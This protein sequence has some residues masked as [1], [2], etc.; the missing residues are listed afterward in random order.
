MR[1]YRKDQDWDSGRNQ[2]NLIISPRLSHFPVR[3]I[4]IHDN[5]LVKIY[6]DDGRKASRLTVFLD[7]AQP[8]WKG[9]MIHF[10]PFYAEEG[11]LSFKSHVDRRGEEIFFMSINKKLVEKLEEK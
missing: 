10:K 7:R 9:S 3:T 2:N 6:S 11:D 1:E 8:E 5:G 4:V